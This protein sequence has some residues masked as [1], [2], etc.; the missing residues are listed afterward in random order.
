VKRRN[1]SAEEMPRGYYSSQCL[2]QGTVYN[3]SPT[4]TKYG[5]SVSYQ[6]KHRYGIFWEF[7]DHI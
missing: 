7:H 1:K 4:L 3:I 5:V 6:Y 2:F